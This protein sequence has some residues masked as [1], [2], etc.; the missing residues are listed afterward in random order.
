MFPSR[1]GLHMNPKYYCTEYTAH[2]CCETCALLD[3]HHYRVINGVYHDTTTDKPT[4]TDFYDYMRVNEIYRA[5]SID[6]PANSDIIRYKV[7]NDVIGE[8]TTPASVPP[9]VENNSYDVLNNIENTTLI[10]A[11]VDISNNEAINVVYKTTSEPATTEGKTEVFRI[12]EGNSTHVALFTITNV[13][14]LPVKDQLLTTEKPHSSPPLPSVQQNNY[15]ETKTTHTLE[16][17]G[18]FS[19]NDT[20]AN[21]TFQFT[22]QTVEQFFTVPPHTTLTEKMRPT[23]EG[24]N[25][26]YITNTTTKY[27]N[28]TTLLE[29]STPPQVTLNT[30]TSLNSTFK[31]TKLTPKSQTTLLSTTTQKPTGQKSKYY[32]YNM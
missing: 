20:G 6:L 12:T 5:P 31:Q 32:L 13:P 10:P 17:I 1:H 11:A 22:G 16:N 18:N 29:T 27:N 23:M 19:S 21:Q 26:T 3:R 14:N 9:L 28:L 15:N 30:T 24:T 7:F 25:S 8:T 4:T 2:R